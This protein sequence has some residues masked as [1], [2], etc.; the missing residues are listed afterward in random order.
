ML[1]TQTTAVAVSPVAEIRE[2]RCGDEELLVRAA[3]ELSATTLR[4]RFLS[5][6]P[7]LPPAYLRLVSTAPRWRWDGQVALRDGQLI[8]WAEFA[9]LRP[10]DT[11]ADLG[12]VVVDAWQRHGV[13]TA[14]VS[15]VLDRCRAAGITLLSAQVAPYNVPARAALRSWF[16]R[17]PGPMT[18][19]LEDG[20]LTFGLLL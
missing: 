14:L 15:S 20:L 1:E 10:E 6:V 12:V 8:G 13:G 4:N 7:T 9:R 16:A 17:Y 3:G 18:A 19:R 5:G 2:W 11:T